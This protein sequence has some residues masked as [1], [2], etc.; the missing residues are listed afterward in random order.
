MA[1]DGKA[2]AARQTLDGT[3]MMQSEGNARVMRG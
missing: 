2:R 1:R 3:D